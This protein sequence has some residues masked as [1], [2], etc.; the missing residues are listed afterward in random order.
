[1]KSNLTRRVAVGM[2]GDCYETLRGPILIAGVT[3]VLPTIQT[4]AQPKRVFQG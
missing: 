1:M 4:F 3:S 2:Y